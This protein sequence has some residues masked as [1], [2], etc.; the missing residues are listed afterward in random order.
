MFN[1]SYKLINLDLMR[2]NL[3]PMYSLLE[4]YPNA[5][6]QWTAG[7][8]NIM[9]LLEVTGCA[10]YFTWNYVDVKWWWWQNMYQKCIFSKTDRKFSF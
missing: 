6:P 4:N 3:N 10:G 9:A 7:L 1:L 5:E 8:D 2:N